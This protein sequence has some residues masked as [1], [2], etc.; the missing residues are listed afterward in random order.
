MKT[1]LWIILGFV[2][3]LFFII[4]F[5]P[6]GGRKASTTSDRPA[7]VTDNPDIQIATMAIRD[8]D[9]PC[10]TVTS[11]V[12]SPRGTGIWALCSNGERYGIIEIQGK[13]LAMRCSA[14]K[15]MGIEC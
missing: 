7:S 15:A 1:A 3:L 5:D 13:T 11:A 4:V 9:H 10:G 6:A 12:R 2:G 8:A 14:L